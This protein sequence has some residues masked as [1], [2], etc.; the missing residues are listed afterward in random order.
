M[1]SLT[2]VDGSCKECHQ[3]IFDAEVGMHCNVFAV[4]TQIKS[5]K[6]LEVCN[7]V[8]GLTYEGSV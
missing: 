7:R 1:A 6:S 5:N 4:T 8:Y 2:K 3:L